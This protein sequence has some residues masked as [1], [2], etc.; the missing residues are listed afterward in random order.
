MFLFVRREGFRYYGRLIKP[1]EE[2]IAVGL[3]GSG[4]VFGFLGWHE[5]V[6]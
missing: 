3:V 6:G 2:E 1:G 5:L 4:P